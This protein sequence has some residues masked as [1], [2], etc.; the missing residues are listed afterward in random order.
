ML[1]ARV[2]VAE[3][4]DHDDSVT[5]KLIELAASADLV[6]LQSP[7][8]PGRRAHAHRDVVADVVRRVGCPVVSV[9]TGA[10]SVAR[11][12]VVVGVDGSDENERALGW[13]RWFASGVGRP[14]VAVHVVDPL[15]RTF[16]PL[17]RPSREEL[18]VRRE[19][20][21]SGAEFVERVSA[22]TAGSLADFAESRSAAI[23][24]VGAGHH[25]GFGSPFGRVA[26]EIVATSP[27]PVAVVPR[28]DG[29]RHGP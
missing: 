19:L 24:V 26:A 1:G 6:V 17:D 9:P 27:R 5:D 21:H 20:E 23:L 29:V 12:P 15:Y 14:I 13:A 7:P 28:H 10:R 2:L 3:P 16:E 11:C 22:D 18:A 25:R 4:Q 8:V